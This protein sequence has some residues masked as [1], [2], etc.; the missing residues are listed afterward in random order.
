M[1]FDPSGNTYLIITVK[2]RK[3]SENKCKYHI[4][5]RY[6]TSCKAGD[7][8]LIFFLISKR[9]QIL[10]ARQIPCSKFKVIYMDMFK[11]I[12]ELYIEI[13]GYLYIQ[14]GKSEEGNLHKIQE[15][16]PKLRKRLVRKALAYDSY[17]QKPKRRNET[18]NIYGLAKSRKKRT[19]NLG[20]IECIQGK[21]IRYRKQQRN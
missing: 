8:M 7:D 1:K 14:F 19:R 21:E 6:K 12:R 9:Y 13:Q 18:K 2:F 5:V 16:N 11:S 15:Q 20:N 17:C 4:N 10:F 3:T